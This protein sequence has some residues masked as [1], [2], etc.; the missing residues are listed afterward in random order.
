M[1]VWQVLGAVLFAVFV[2]LVA[3]DIEYFVLNRGSS[4]TGCLLGAEPC[5]WD[6][7]RVKPEAQAATPAPE[8]S[9]TPSP[10]EPAICIRDT[11]SQYGYIGKSAEANEH[12]FVISTLAGDEGQVTI[13]RDPA[14]RPGVTIRGRIRCDGPVWLDVDGRRVVVN[15]DQLRQIS[16]ARHVVTRSWRWVVFELRLYGPSREVLAK[17]RFR[18]EDVSS[19]CGLQGKLGAYYGCSFQLYFPDVLPHRISGYG[20]IFVEG[21]W[22]DYHVIGGPCDEG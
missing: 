22:E 1:S 15:L 5:P 6:R 9:K 13:L 14:G 19:G 12:L 4:M 2:V 21:E 11:Y 20:L 8:Q 10:A 7:D 18:M 16:G 3:Q 17:E